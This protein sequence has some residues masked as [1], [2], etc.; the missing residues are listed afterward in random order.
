V[1]RRYEPDFPIV[2]LLETAPGRIVTKEQLE[3]AGLVGESEPLRRT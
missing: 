2:T 1:K 3:A